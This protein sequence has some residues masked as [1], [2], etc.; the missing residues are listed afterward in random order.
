[1]MHHAQSWQDGNHDRTA[2]VLSFYSRAARDGYARHCAQR[3]D[4]IPYATAGRMLR[5]GRAQ[6]RV[7]GTPARY[8]QPE[9][10]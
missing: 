8:A 7:R 5:E 4:P 3:F 10:I 1:M 2:V 9:A 6:Y